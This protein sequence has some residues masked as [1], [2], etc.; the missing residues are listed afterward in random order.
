MMTNGYD[1]LYL[2]AF[3]QFIETWASEEIGSNVEVDF[4]KVFKYLTSERFF[5]QE[6]ENSGDLSEEELYEVALKSVEAKV[7]AGFP[8]W[9]Y[10][11]MSDWTKRMLEVTFQ[12]EADKEL[13][14]AKKKY[15]CLSCRFF[16]ITRYAMGDKDH[17]ANLMKME[18][19]KA[20]HRRERWHFC[21]ED[22]KRCAQWE[23][24]VEEEKEQD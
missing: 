3:L 19:M 1:A 5:F 14:E 23:A 11:R 22:V 6:F 10:L 21:F 12:S 13:S 9:E 7:L 24:K 8:V 15:P 18:A 17:C 2:K 16:S 4:V 20:A